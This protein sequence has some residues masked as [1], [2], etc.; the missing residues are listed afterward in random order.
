MRLKLSTDL[1][2]TPEDRKHLVEKHRGCTEVRVEEIRWKRKDGK[3]I[4]VRSAGRATLDQQGETTGFEMIVENVT[5]RRTLEEQLRQSQKM[6]AVG[7]LAGG[8]AHDFNNL[9]TVIKGYSEMMLNEMGPDSPIRVEAQEVKKAADRAGA[10]TRQLL[11]FSRRQVLAPRVLDLNSVVA[12]MDKLLRPLLREDILFQTILVEDLGPVKADP[13]QIEQVIMNLVVNAKDALPHGG[14][15]VV[16]TSNVILNPDSVPEHARMQPGSYVLLSVSDSG[17]GMDETTRLRIF[18]PFFTTKEMGQGTGLGL[19]TVYG[20]VKQ[21]GGYIWVSSEPGAGATFKVYL[22]R[23]NA[24]P[25]SLHGNEGQWTSFRGTE[26]VLLVEDEDGVR[27]LVRHI[28]QKQ[29][30]TVLEAR[31]GGEAL[32]LCERF[33]DP[34]H[35]LLTDVILE[36]MNGRELAERLAWVRPEMKTLYISG[37]TDDAILHH[38]ALVA[39]MPFLQKPFTAEGLA[40]KV[41]RVLDGQNH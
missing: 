9:L 7:R 11:A 5:E 20:I 33:P 4:H 12:G 30:Y 14:T 13:G 25:E 37:Y 16:Q 1:Y 21:S 29:G 18:E 19:S 39:E 23:V 10:L 2:V 24:R 34:I 17:V 3:V 35:L 15:L 8:I 32:G 22:P 27:T 36:Q 38:G 26:T 6:E 28:L 41:R 31:R 40:T